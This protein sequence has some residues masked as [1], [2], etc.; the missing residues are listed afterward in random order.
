M[1]V[2]R[3]PQGPL[4]FARLISYR[5]NEETV[6]F[7]NKTEAPRTIEAR[8]DDREYLIRDG[9]R[10]DFLAHREIGDSA[11]GHLIMLRNETEDR[12]MRLWPND[13]V[14]GREISIPTRRGLAE[15]GLL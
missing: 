4:R 9:D 8:D 3:N 1:A 2:R 7:W 6:L 10:Q 15:R 13:F 11:A 14:M 5:E 12:P